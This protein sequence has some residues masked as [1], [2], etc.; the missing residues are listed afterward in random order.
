MA[1]TDVYGYDATDQ[2]TQVK[3]NYD[4]TT[5][6]QDRLV[7]YA[8]DEAGNRSSLTDNGSAT[9]YSANSLSRHRGKNTRANL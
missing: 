3:Y 8:Y 6:L 2:I 1:S 5:Q 4:A 9:S 7:D